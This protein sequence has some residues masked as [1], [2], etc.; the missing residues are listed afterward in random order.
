VRFLTSSHSLFKWS[1]AKRLR[2][3]IASA[4]KSYIYSSSVSSFVLISDT[5]SSVSPELGVQYSVKVGVSDL[6]HDAQMQMPQLV[7]KF[8]R[9]P[10]LTP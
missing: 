9:F 4:S 8:V 10:N 3:D 7:F 6:V 5:Y 2:I 1:S